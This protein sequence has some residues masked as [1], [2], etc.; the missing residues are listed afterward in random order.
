MA[1][2][3]SVEHLSKASFLWQGKVQPLT[4]ER[5]ECYDELEVLSGI[6]I[7][8]GKEV[9]VA[10]LTP[11]DMKSDNIWVVRAIPLGLVPISFGYGMEPLGMQ[12]IVAT[13]RH[14]SLSRHLWQYNKPFT[15][16]FA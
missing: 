4:C 12:R 15:H 6:F 16:P 8:Q 9:I 7:S 14:L 11:P 13:P 1:L 2:Y 5:N 10:D 3:S